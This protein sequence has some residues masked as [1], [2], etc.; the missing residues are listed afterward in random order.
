MSKR[1]SKLYIED[2]LQAIQK[3]EKYTKDMLFPD[4]EEDEK[5]VMLL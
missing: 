3:I 1:E 4:F 2:I 5:T